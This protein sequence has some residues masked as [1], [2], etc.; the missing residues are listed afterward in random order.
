MVDPVKIGYVLGGHGAAARQRRID[1]VLSRADSSIDIHFIDVDAAM[2]ARNWTPYDSAL[3]EPAFVAGFRRAEAE[4]CLAVIP[5]G[6]LDLGVE[7]GRS[8]VRIPVV[9]PFQAALHL[10]ALAG[11][12]IGHIHYTNSYVPNLW[13]ATQRYGMSSFVVETVGLDIEMIDLA[14]QLDVVRERIVTLGNDLIKRQA[15]D[16]IIAS[17][18]GL[19]PV[20]ICPDWLGAELG[21]PVIEGIGAPLHLAASLARLRLAQSPR[22][23]QPAT[24]R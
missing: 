15:V 24:Q 23:W 20:T 9:A 8:A 18:P 22:R 6:M 5:D 21:L 14:V 17:G 12:R 4:G 3:A 11:S 10:A 7:A 16:V 13:A 1:A 19:C 2:E